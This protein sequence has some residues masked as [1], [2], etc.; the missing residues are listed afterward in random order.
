MSKYDMCEMIYA[1][2]EG[3]IIPR[4]RSVVVPIMVLV[5][6]IVLLGLTAVI[7]STVENGNLRSALMLFGA[8]FAVVGL[9]IIV[10][11]LSGASRAPYCVK[12]GCF[13]DKKELK[14]T[15]EQKNIIIDL[16]RKG[17]FTTLR[18]LKQNDVSALVVIEYS[19]PKSRVAACQAFEYLELELRPVSDL[20][21]KVE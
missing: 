1:Q 5:L 17:D 13:L 18:N 9:V 2:T 21:L 16:L 6:G 15:K 7:E 10:S 11:R 19:S 12:D 14:F 8:I 3:A 4:R 20:V